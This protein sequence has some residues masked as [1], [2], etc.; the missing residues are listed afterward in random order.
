MSSLLGHS[1][2]NVQAVQRR[3]RVIVGYMARTLLNHCCIRIEF[4]KCISFG[5]FN[6]KSPSNIASRKRCSNKCSSKKKGI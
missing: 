6:T 1:V 3:T 5:V 2:S 4:F